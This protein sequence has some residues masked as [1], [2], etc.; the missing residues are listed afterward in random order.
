M[1]VEKILRAEESFNQT[2]GVDFS[3]EK[4]EGKLDTLTDLREANGLFV[5]AFI[6]LYKKAYGNFVDRRIGAR[7]DFVEMI[8]NFE[9]SIMAPYRISREGAGKSAPSPY[10]AL[11]VSEYLS[12]VKEFLDGLPA[13]KTDYARSRYVG[14]ELS[15]GDMR[16]LLSLVSGKSE[17]TDGELSTL[18]CYLGALSAEHT[19]RPLIDNLLHP[20]RY[21]D[22]QKCINELSSFLEEKTEGPLSIHDDNE[23]YRA[24]SAI[25]RDE[26]IKLS[27]K[28]VGTTLAEAVANERIRA[29]EA[30]P[31]KQKLSISA[32][33]LIDSPTVN[34]VK[35]REKKQ[36]KIVE[37]DA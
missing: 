36:E 26:T 14:Q 27:A 22:E 4:F 33:E 37:H 17:V 1:V 32:A 31:K 18:D 28:V 8:K 6:P 20:L 25:S 29:A 2:Y 19:S 15:I 5:S 7:F 23:R 3:I 10:G 11:T 24:V 34:T 9:K 16:G 13:Y 21:F 35:D 30:A 12:S